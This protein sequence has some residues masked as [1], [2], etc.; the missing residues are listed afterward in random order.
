MKGLPLITDVALQNEAALAGAAT[1]EVD[2][3]LHEVALG[4]EV[5]IHG[6]V[7][8]GNTIGGEAA[9]ANAVA[10]SEVALADEVDDEAPD[11]AHDILACWICC[12]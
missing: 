11:E 12:S 9:R 10:L 5:V 3:A 8:L 4:G 2:V 7:A 1:L 6:K